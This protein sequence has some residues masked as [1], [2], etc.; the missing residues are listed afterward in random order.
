MKKIICPGCGWSTRVVY[1][2]SKDSYQ[3]MDCGQ[4][5]ERGKKL[6]KEK[7]YRCPNCGHEWKEEDILTSETIQTAEE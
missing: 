2:S 1:L 3:C 6:I 5:W 4:I 7:A